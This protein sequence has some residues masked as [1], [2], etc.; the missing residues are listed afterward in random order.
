MNEAAPFRAGPV[1]HLLKLLLPGKLCLE[2]CRVW[3]SRLR[4][5]RLPGVWYALIVGV[6]FPPVR[7]GDEIVLAAGA[8]ARGRAGKV[9][10]RARIERGH[11]SVLSFA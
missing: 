3:L 4:R 5:C 10:H 7:D 6:L 2:Q 9:G 1:G 11:I 8:S